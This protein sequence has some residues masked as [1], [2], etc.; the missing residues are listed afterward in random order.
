MQRVSLEEVDGP[1]APKMR[2]NNLD[3]LVK[4][5][6]EFLSR[7]DTDRIYPVH[8][9]RDELIT[10]GNLMANR[11]MEDKNSKVLRLLIRTSP[12]QGSVRIISIQ[13]FIEKGS[14]SS[15]EKCERET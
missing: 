8:I 4:W 13:Y 12:D 5:S 9:I 10:M 6:N 1:L 14:H 2:L 3:R 7:R 11:D 15:Q